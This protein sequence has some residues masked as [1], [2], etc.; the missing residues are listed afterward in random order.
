MRKVLPFIA[1]IL[2]L[3]CGGLG[4]GC[5]TLYK[6]VNKVT[7]E[8]SQLIQQSGILQASIDAIGPITEVL[9]VNKPV[10]AGDVVRAEDLALQTIPQSS[11][12]ERH[13]TNVQDCLGMVFKIDLLPGTSITSDLLMR[14]ALNEITYERDLSFS[15]LPLGLEVGDFIDVRV[16]LP[17]GEEF[18]VLQHE[19]VEQLV[20]ESNIIKLY[21]NEEQLTLWTSVLKDYAIY[22]DKGFSYYCVKYLEPGI[23]Q[24]AKAFYPVR[25]EMEDTVAK[26]PNIKHP[27]LCVNTELRNVI[28]SKLDTVKDEHSGN[29]ASG[30]QN[31][32]S[33]LT[34]SK[35]Q[36]EDSKKDSP[37]V[38]ADKNFRDNVGEAMDTIVN[39]DPDQILEGTGDNVTDNS[40]DKSAGEPV[41]GGESPIE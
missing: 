24:E 34:G 18:T 26:N 3:A 19:R 22:R 13:F 11:I 37:S 6:T 40:I 10:K 29:L 30:A 21:L 27:E 25:S 35:N 39:F 31:E 8:R 2:L 15:F 33:K 9:T 16:V 23:T 14:E 12:T 17:Y 4:Y 1:I 38:S 28:N 41:Y 7:S 36:Y 32:A 20:Y 5:I